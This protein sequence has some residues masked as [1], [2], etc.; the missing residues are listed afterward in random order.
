MNRIL[1][2]FASRHGSTDEVAHE[3]G[4]VPSAHDTLVDGRR[5][6]AAGTCWGKTS[7]RS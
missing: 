2:A 5:Y 3:I 1:V 4:R 6:V 7:S